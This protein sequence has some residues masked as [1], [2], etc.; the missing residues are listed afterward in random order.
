M[1]TLLPNPTKN[2]GRPAIALAELRQHIRTLIT[3][4]ATDAPV[5]SCYLNLEPGTR[6]SGV[7]DYQHVLSERVALLRKSMTGGR[8]KHLDEAL[9]HIEAY[10]V[11]MVRPGTKGAAIFAR[12]GE[13]PLFLPLQFQVPLPNWVTVD[14]I[15]NVYHLVELKDTYHRFVLLLMTEKS[16]RI[17]D[18]NLGA[19]TEE[20]WAERPE[21]RDRVG[22]GW[23]KMHY[24]HHREQQTE[25]FIA[26]EIQVLDRLMSAGG[27]THLILAGNPNMT[28]RM[29]EALP[30]HLAEK[31]VDTV[32]A[33]T[34]DTLF[35]IV[36]ATNSLFVEHEEA[37][38]LDRVRQL[39]REINT[40][41][42]AVAGT[43]ASLRALNGRQADVLIMAKAYRPDPGWACVPCGEIRAAPH[44]PKLCPVCLGFELREVDLQGEMVRLA[45]QNGAEVEIVG[46]SDLLMELGG[47]GCL[48]RY[49]SQEP[50]GR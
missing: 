43:A 8:K 31:L 25:R 26:D 4:E 19:V 39:E 6:E 40:H 48:L 29:Q 13:R 7:T 28:A 24:Q 21:L 38:S 32:H 2:G 47:V 1:N 11:G 49:Q 50:I 37:E 35:D 34:R 5:I 42:L 3:L 10:L 41:G 17:L 33:S 44:K 14:V 45:E 30:R 20:V 15:P 18:I 36:A 12:G 46:H 27:H 9:G 16:A 23:A 22:S